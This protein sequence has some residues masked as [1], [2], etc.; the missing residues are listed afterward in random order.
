M[1]T[2]LLLLGYLVVAV[3]ESWFPAASPQSWGPRDVSLTRVSGAV[4]GDV[5]VIDAADPGSTALLSI[6]TDI[7]SAD[8]RTI[9]WRLANVPEQADVRMFW[10]SDYAPAKTNS[11]PVTIAAGRLLPVDVSREATWLGRITGIALA[12]RNPLSQPVQFHDVTAKPMGALE[13]LRDRSREWLAFERWTGASMNA[14]T[15]GATVQNLPLPFL[16]AV[17]ALVAMLASL[18]LLRRISRAASLPV[19]IGAIFVAAWIV[20]DLRWEWNLARQAIA[21]RDQYAGKDW[22]GKHLAAEDGAL[23]A[24]LERVRAKLPPPPARIFVV[25]EAHYLRDRAA[26]HLYPHN[27]HF[28]PYRDAVPPSASLRADDYLLVYGRRGIQYDS[29]AQRLRFPDGTTLAAEV[30]LVEPGAALFVIR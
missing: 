4:E 8:Y 17:A 14:I 2:L 6:K 10:R 9:A 1:A 16:L 11:A 23:F 24:S 27:V 30:L 29:K 25:A 15:G 28:D 5:L 13:L 19:A 26:Y 22:R 18:F 21:T 7:R 12:I 20:A 3:P